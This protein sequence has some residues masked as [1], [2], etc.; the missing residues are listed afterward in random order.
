M[1]EG[2]AAD[3]T[4]HTSYTAWATQLKLRYRNENIIFLNIIYEGI[5]PLF[6]L[7]ACIHKRILSRRFNSETNQYELQCFGF[8][9]ILV[10]PTPHCTDGVIIVQFGFSKMAACWLL[11]FN[12]LGSDNR[13]S[14]QSGKCAIGQALIVDLIRSMIWSL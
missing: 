2:L 12:L 6:S 7:V 8:A 1:N 13:L 14:G 5:S 3:W 4:P 11:P 9:A 10:Y